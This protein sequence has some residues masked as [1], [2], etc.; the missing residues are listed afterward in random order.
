MEKAFFELESYAFQVLLSKKVKN[1]IGYCN[2]LD[3]DLFC[4]FNSMANIQ[5]TQY[6][7]TYSGIKLI[8]MA[9]TPKNEK[10]IDQMIPK[11]VYGF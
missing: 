8:V 4:H 2:S 3:Q 11:Q 6:S 9:M 5:N 10:R 7:N 1:L